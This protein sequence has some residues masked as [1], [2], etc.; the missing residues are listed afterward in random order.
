MVIW[1]NYNIK[2]NN[3]IFSAC[4]ST[5]VASLL[6]PGKSHVVTDA[7]LTL[8]HIACVSGGECH[9]TEVYR[10]ASIFIIKFKNSSCNIFRTDSAS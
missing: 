8:L 10:Q 9:L 1:C 2:E 6:K 4:D 5:Q 7:G 3:C